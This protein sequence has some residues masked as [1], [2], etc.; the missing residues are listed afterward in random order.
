MLQARHIE[1]TVVEYLKT[2]PSVAELEQALQALHMDARA[3]M[4]VNEPVYAQVGAG[5]PQ[6]GRE[7][8]LEL[9]HA[10]PI[11]IQRPV[12]FAGTQARIGRPPEAVL[13]IL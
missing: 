8:L 6:L 11:L 7:Q 12:V 9:M 1:P 3:L 2:P 5:D 4:R 10:H 13:E